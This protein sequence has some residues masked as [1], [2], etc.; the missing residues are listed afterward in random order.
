MK[1]ILLLS[2][3]LLVIL[4]LTYVLFS[5]NLVYIEWLDWTIQIDAFFLLFVWLFGYVILSIFLGILK[6]PRRIK[7]FLQRRKTNKST[8]Q[9]NKALLDYLSEDFSEATELF[10]NI[11][12]NDHDFEAR[13]MSSAALMQLGEM[14][15]STTYIRKLMRE[16]PT[17]SSILQCL[18]GKWQLQQKEYHL[19][20]ETLAS[21]IK[22]G[23]PE[24][25]KWFLFMQA[26]QHTGRIN[27]WQLLL[28]IAKRELSRQDFKKLCVTLN[29]LQ[30][31]QA[32]SETQLNSI[33]KEFNTATKQ[34]PSIIKA[35]LDTSSYLQSNVND[36]LAKIKQILKQQWRTDWLWDMVNY[37]Q[38]DD[39][40]H[41]LDWCKN[42]VKQKQHI[43][44]CSYFLSLA[45][46]AV[47][48][49]LWAISEDF[50]IQANKALNKSEENQITMTLIKGWIQLKIEGKPVPNQWSN[51]MQQHGMIWAEN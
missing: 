41:L 10:S 18:L 1:K 46:I 9:F 21:E 39:F 43:E 42:T 20:Y 13:L 4:T 28:P 49:Q 33:W 14:T 23:S 47:R 24:P 50:L 44:D 2:L 51:L 36:M 25:K 11:K 48:A 30:L 31:K 45:V 27:E 6:T 32:E 37:K 3:V 35:Y 22:Q 19:A 17:Q 12:E 5:G 34:T 8:S 29:T 15:K 7:H 40:H 16:Y 38:V 26:T